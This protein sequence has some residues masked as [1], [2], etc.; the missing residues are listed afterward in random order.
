VTV[1]AKP[2]VV[3][4][5][6]EGVGTIVLQRGP[7]NAYDTAFLRELADVIGRVRD[8]DAVRVAVI[9]SA[10]PRF[11][12][13]GADISTL[14]GATKAGFASFLLL[15][16]STVNAIGFTPK[17][18][19]AAIDG[20]CIGGGLELALA[21]DFRIA[22]EGAYKLG[23]AEVK[24][25]LSPG[26]GGTQRLPRLIRQSVALELMVTGDTVSPERALELGI[27]DR[28]V[29]SETFASE[30]DAFARKLAAGATLAQG[31]IKL[32]VNEGLDLELDAALGAERAHSAQLF[33]TEDVAEGIAAFLEKR[34]ARFAGR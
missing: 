3:L 11:F 34:P 32:A 22:A 4:D 1:E 9:R 2:S 8:D 25:G 7:A 24:L 17:L 33:G 6:A 20:H 29:P 30:V 19:V 26:M 18:F 21:C 12:C 27:V 31:H 5:V 16:H 13:S 28:L 10:V 23:L 15:A 14:H